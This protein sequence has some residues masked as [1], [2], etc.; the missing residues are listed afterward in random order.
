[1]VDQ[2]KEKVAAYRQ[3][4]ARIRGVPGHLGQVVIT[5]CANVYAT[6]EINV[7]EIMTILGNVH[8]SQCFEVPQNTSHNGPDGRC[9]HTAIDLVEPARE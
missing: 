8:Q 6:V 4:L 3:S 2:S 5:R 7:W 9:G 1:M